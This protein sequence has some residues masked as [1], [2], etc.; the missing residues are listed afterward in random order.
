MAI[1]RDV[2]PAHCHSSTTHQ[3]QSAPLRLRTDLHAE[4]EL[5][6]A[7][8]GWSAIRWCSTGRLMRRNCG[9]AVVY[10]LKSAK[11]RVQLNF[12]VFKTSLILKVI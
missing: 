6:R 7:T 8:I 3:P 4:R 12:N 9:Q 5:L 10:E 2:L 1:D 11:A